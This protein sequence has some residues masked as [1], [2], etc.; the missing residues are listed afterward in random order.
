VTWWSWEIVSYCCG[1][2]SLGIFF[3]N[4]AS[5][6][7][8]NILNC[9]MY[10]YLVVILIVYSFFSKSLFVV[11]RLQIISTPVGHC[12]FLQYDN[13]IIPHTNGRW[14]ITMKNV[15]DSITWAQN[16]ALREY[17]YCNRQRRT[18]WILFIWAIMIF[19][20]RQH[21]FMSRNIK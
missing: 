9:K 19:W 12:L 10:I 17:C 13:N 3:V 14:H 6:D 16:A 8:I 5:L 7:I 21:V 2:Q 11:H 1:I 18:S 15:V 20:R 4:T